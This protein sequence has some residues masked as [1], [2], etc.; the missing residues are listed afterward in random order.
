M[1]SLVISGSFLAQASTDET[2]QNR[3]LQNNNVI[4]QRTAEAFDQLWRI[5]ILQE[6]VGNVAT[7]PGGGLYALLARLGLYLALGTLILFMVRWT[8]QLLEG[9]MQK[10]ISDLIWPLLVVMLLA[11]QG[12]LLANTT[13]GIR[14]LINYVSYSALSTLDTSLNIESTLAGVMNYRILQEEMANIVS[15]CDQ[16]TQDQEKLRVCLKEA[17]RELEALKEEYLQNPNKFLKD[18]GKAE[19]ERKRDSLDD[20]LTSPPKPIPRDRE[21][22]KVSEQLLSLGTAF[23]RTIE[24]CLLVT[25]LAGP[26]AVGASLLPFGNKPIFAWLSALLSLGLAKL[27]YNLLN[28]VVIVSVYYTGVTGNFLYQDFATGAI[29]PLLAFGLAAGGGKALFDGLLQANPNLRSEIY[30][31]DYRSASGVQSSNRK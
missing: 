17:Q 5:I 19:I 7:P 26:L 23:Q 16:F 21:M 30:G 14:N 15:Q 1:Y 3:F 12:K 25:A 24:S 8:R 10:S 31:G 6:S 29:N 22:N 2:L 9:E 13:F 28:A 20:P 27:S 18:R 11:N 4:T